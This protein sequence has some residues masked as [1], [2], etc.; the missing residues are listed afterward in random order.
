MLAAQGR[1]PKVIR[2]NRLSR[3]SQFDADSCVVKCSLFVN[4]E[5]SAVSNEAI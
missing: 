1:N 4:I 5:H 2:W 3:L